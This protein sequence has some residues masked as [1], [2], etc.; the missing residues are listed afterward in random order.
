MGNPWVNLLFALN[1]AAAVATL[2]LLWR[3]DKLR[4]TPSFHV[5]AL[6]VAVAIYATMAC[7]SAATESGE[8]GIPMVFGIHVFIGAVVWAPFIVF[9]AITYVRVLGEMASGGASTTEMKIKDAAHDVEF[10]HDARAGK[11]L[12]GVL[13]AEPENVEAHALMGEVQLKRGDYEKA[14]GSFRLAMANAPGNGEFARFAFRAAVI[15]NE[16]L[17]EPKAAA[18]ELDLIRKRMPNTPESEKAQDWIV[19]L[20]DDAAKEE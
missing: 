6:S 14:L 15:L 5:G 11:T 10:G 7:L 13:A 16:H 8:S 12:R 9:L 1:A 2:V 4:E 17:G 20:M 3:R 18:R 19:R